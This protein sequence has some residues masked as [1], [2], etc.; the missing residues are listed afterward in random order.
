MLPKGG[1]L[2]DIAAAQDKLPTL[3]DV[4]E[5]AKTKA[6]IFNNE[7]DIVVTAIFMV[8]VVLI[9]VANAWLWLRLLTKQSESVLH[10]EPAV[11][12]DDP[13]FADLDNYSHH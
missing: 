11:P 5:I 9:V 8:L 7:V 1:F 3:T 10:E 4:S 6:Q 2:S 13:K 12:L